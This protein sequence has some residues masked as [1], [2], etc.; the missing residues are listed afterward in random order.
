MQGPLLL[1]KDH[2]FEVR[3]KTINLLEEHTGVN[4]RD[5]GPDNRFLAMIPKE[6]AR[7]RKTDQL[8]TSTRSFGG[9]SLPLA[10]GLAQ[11]QDLTAGRLPPGP[12][13]PGSPAGHSLASRPD[14][15]TW[16]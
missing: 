10:S 7:K 11:P 6:Q 13:A 16:N 4:L 12:C 5:L 15:R 9:S 14:G 2:F 3:A 1:K 8:D